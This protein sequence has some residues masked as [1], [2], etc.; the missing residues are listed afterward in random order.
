CIGNSGPLPA[1][2]T[3]QIAEHDLVVASVLSGN[4]NFEGRIQSEVRANYLMSPPLVV[5]YALA[6]HIEKDITQDA[7]GTGKDGRPVYLKEI[8]PTPKE[9]AETV[10]KCIDSGM[11]KKNYDEIFAGDDLWKSMKVPGGETFAWDAKST[12][13][14]RAPYFDNMPKTPAP[15]EDIRNA[16]VLAKLGDSVTT[17]HISPAGSIKAAS[18]AGKY[19]NEHSVAVVDFNSYGSRRGNHEIMVRGTFAN[20]RLRNLIAPGTEGGVTR[21]LPDGKPMS[22][23]EA[24]ELYKQEG[25]PLLILAGKEYGSGSSRDWAGKGP[26]LLGVKAVIAQSYERIHRSNLVGMGVLPLQFLPEE[27]ADSLGLTGEESF[28]ISG[29]AALLNKEFKSGEK[30]NVHATH[31]DGS[32][33]DFHTVVRID[34]PQE[35]LYYRH[36]GILQYVLRQLLNRS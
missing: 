10:A 11:F 24:S 22:I 23:F 35:A 27:D 21:H 13:I 5:A 3:Q 29:I 26:S 7:L 28:A 12:Y 8:W 34:T 14:K 16:R 31:A 20:T 6:G 1:E 4:R 9:V 36:G 18:P 17:D 19:L 15:V 2:I 32:K 30:V 25:V 33:I